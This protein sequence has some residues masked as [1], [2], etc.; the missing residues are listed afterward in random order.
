MARGRKR[1]DMSSNSA[2][3]AATDH[4][5]SAATNDQNGN[6]GDGGMTAAAAKD[7]TDVLRGLLAVGE[8]HV[9]PASNDDDDNVPSSASAAAAPDPISMLKAQLDELGLTSSSTAD[10]QAAIISYEPAKLK[11]LREAKGSR[12]WPAY[13]DKDFLNAKGLWDP[14][15]W[16]QGRKRGSTPPPGEKPPPRERRPLRGEGDGGEERPNS[17]LSMEG[18]VIV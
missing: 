14:D 15:R 18:K 16:H 17:S 8:K 5:A 12:T 4:P 1:K 3:A 10:G 9:V 2:A 13:L 6:H 7:A 11:E